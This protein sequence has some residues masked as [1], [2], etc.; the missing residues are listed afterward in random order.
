[1]AKAIDVINR[2]MRL[3]GVAQSGEPLPSDVAADALSVFNSLLAEWYGNIAIPEYS[4][5]GL[6]ATLTMDD[7]DVEALAYQ[8]ALRM[9]PEYGFSVPQ[10]FV[11]G[12]KESMS[13]LRMRYFVVGSVDF[14]E[15]PLPTGFGA[16]SD[17]NNA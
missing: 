13:R 10:E 15:L 11:I 17:P 5:A 14:T 6:T 3:I 16:L 9:A 12:A 2:A 7:G 8:L 4:I 1:M